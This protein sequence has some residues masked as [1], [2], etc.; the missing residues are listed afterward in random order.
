MKYSDIGHDKLDA[1]MVWIFN[2]NKRHSGLEWH[3]ANKGTHETLYG[4]SYV[5]HWRGRID[6]PTRVCSVKAPANSKEAA[7]PEWLL[8]LLRDEFGNET[9]I[10]NFG[11]GEWCID[12]E[13]K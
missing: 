3:R 9:N 5:N 7:C 13:A 4:P 6:L 1:A 8:K 12:K 11:V 10:V 2:G